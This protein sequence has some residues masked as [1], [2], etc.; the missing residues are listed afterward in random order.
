L[1]PLVAQGCECDGSPAK[2]SQKRLGPIDGQKQM[3]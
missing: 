2:G 1:G 3:A